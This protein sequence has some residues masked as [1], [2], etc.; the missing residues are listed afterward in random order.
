MANIEASDKDMKTQLILFIFLAMLINVSSS[1]FGESTEAQR[2]YNLAISYI[3]SDLYEDGLKTLNQVAFLYPDSSVADDA[4]YQLAL[5][6]E[7]V[8]DKKIDIGSKIGVEVM[9][10]ELSRLNDSG[11]SKT[12]WGQIGGIINGINAVMKREIVINKAQNQALAQYIFA[13]DYLN[14]LIQHYPDSDRQIE[15]KKAGSRIIMKADNILKHPKK[16]PTGLGGQ[17]FRGFAI[18][19][20]IAMFVKFANW[21]F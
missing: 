6:R 5:I 11:V 13:L 14:T 17:I 12:K 15:A 4:L 20:I 16:E 18:L 2:N 8:G 19:L 9:N 1:T 7:Q 21:E 3:K 10:E